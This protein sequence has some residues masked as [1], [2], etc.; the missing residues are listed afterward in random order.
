M[1]APAALL[2]EARAALQRTYPLLLDPSP[3]NIDLCGPHLVS[4]TSKIRELHEALA[5]A[6]VKGRE[7]KESADLLR[8]E[9]RVVSALLDRAA[10]YHSGLLQ[11][12]LAAFASDA[13]PSAGPSPA[14]RLHLEG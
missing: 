6:P 11:E 8:V 14:R 10:A 5:A 2:L 1:S 9:V 13:P 12:M 7:V 3:S 4:A